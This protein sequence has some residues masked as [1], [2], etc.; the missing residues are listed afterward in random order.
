MRIV[1]GWGGLL[2]GGQDRDGPLAVEGRLLGGHMPAG[3][4][5]GPGT[6]DGSFEGQ[7]GCG[8]RLA[9]QAVP[10]VRGSVSGGAQ[11]GV[12]LAGDIALETADDLC[13]RQA[14]CGAPLVVLHR[15]AVNA[16]LRRRPVVPCRLCR[17]PIR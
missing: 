5:W 4:K 9:G 8:S 6:A 2:G 11:A 15:V 14:L 12:D 17:P 1:P 13:F 10:G 7:Q 16:R 3:W